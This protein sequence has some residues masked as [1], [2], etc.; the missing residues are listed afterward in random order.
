MAMPQPM[1]ST[2]PW[3]IHPTCVVWTL[4]RQDVADPEIV[5]SPQHPDRVVQRI[6]LPPQRTTTIFDRTPSPST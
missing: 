2:R 5:E 3:R 1:E 6:E 4:S